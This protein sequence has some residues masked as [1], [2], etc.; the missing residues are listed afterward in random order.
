MRPQLRR[1]DLLLAPLNLRAAWTRTYE[2]NY[3]HLQHASLHQM[4]RDLCKVRWG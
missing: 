2:N 4:L 3:G 1:R